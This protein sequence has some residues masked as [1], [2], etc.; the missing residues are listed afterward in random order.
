MSDAKRALVQ[1][2]GPSFVECSLIHQARQLGWHVRHTVVHSAL[3][4]GSERR[5]GIISG[6]RVPVSTAG[7]P[8]TRRTASRTP[9]TAT[10]SPSSTDLA[11]RRA[12]AKKPSWLACSRCSSYLW[13]SDLFFPCLPF[14]PSP[15]LSLVEKSTDAGFIQFYRSLPEVGLC[16]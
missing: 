14:P 15:S 3:E 2:V 5:E 13:V 4:G 11:A 9:H 7:R 8:P 1:L 16:R 10:S 6:E 12:C